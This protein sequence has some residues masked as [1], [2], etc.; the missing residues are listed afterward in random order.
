MLPPRSCNLA[1]GRAVGARRFHAVRNRPERVQGVLI[2]PQS[3][4]LAGT[5]APPERNDQGDDYD[6]ASDDE[7]DSHRAHSTSIRADVDRAEFGRDRPWQETGNQ[8][9][10]A[11][12]GIV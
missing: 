6:D 4:L 10:K 3:L 7:T 5:G 8:N 12:E 2:V 1:R 9:W 11:A